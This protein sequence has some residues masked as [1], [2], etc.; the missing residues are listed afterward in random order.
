MY[1]LAHNNSVVALDAAT[2]KEIWVRQQLPAP[3]VIT[4][5]GINY[6]ESADRSDRRLFFS[7]DHVLH[8]IDARTGKTIES[9]GK[10]GWGRFEGRPGARS[11][12]FQ[13]GAIDLRLVVFLRI[14]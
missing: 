9:F 5:R 2:G 11:S 13:A 12:K 10:E 6:W 7:A 4:N 8:A 14:C 3:K 1:V